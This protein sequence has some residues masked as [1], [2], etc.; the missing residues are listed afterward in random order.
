[1]RRI[2]P[3]G[4]PRPAKSI[5]ADIAA[6]ERAVRQ[7]QQQRAALLAQLKAQ[8]EAISAAARNCAKRRTPCP[9]E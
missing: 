2:R 8:E 6:K 4:R 1:V 9:A 5:Q 3:R 7:Q